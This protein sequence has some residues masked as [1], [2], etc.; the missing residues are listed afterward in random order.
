MTKVTHGVMSDDSTYCG[1]RLS[2]GE[3]HDINEKSGNYINTTWNE[4]SITCKSC[5]RAIG[6]LVI[7]KPKKTSNADIQEFNERAQ[8]LAD[9]ILKFEL[10]YLALTKLRDGLTLDNKEILLIRVSE[11]RMTLIKGV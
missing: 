10:D 9:D 1:L 11:L 4:E 6:W 7:T 8:S 5:L 3:T 2:I